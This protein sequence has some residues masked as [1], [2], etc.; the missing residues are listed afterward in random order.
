MEE[1]K[2]VVKKEK[3]II[4]KNTRDEDVS[5]KDY[6]YSKDGKDTAH[7]KFN[8]MCGLPVDREEL[9]T[10]FDKIFK[11][12]DNFLFYKVKDKEVYIVIVPLKYASTVGDSNES[13]EGDFQKHAISFIAEGSVSVDSMK[14]KLQKVANTIKI[15]V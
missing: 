1:E 8:L 3:K 7:E 2:K 5:Q 10:V 6:F 11:P 12:E 15:V 4:L 13:M 9:L 14:M